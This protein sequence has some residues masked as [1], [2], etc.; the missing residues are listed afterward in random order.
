MCV[1]T[2][3]ARCISQLFK[4]FVAVCCVSVSYIF[5]FE[6][7][8]I[9][10]SCRKNVETKKSHSKWI[11]TLIDSKWIVYVV[12]HKISVKKLHFEYVRITKISNRKIPNVK[13]AAAHQFKTFDAHF[14]FGNGPK[15]LSPA[16]LYQITL[17]KSW[18]ISCADK[19][20]I[21][22]F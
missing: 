8:C 16:N 22:I 7:L 14:H 3:S 12:E 19:H 10:S 5:K 20:T 15:L 21:C 9:V 17:H 18:L 2:L 6:F 11:F 4:C 1:V 13:N